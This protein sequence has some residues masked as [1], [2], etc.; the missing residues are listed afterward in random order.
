MAR[1]DSSTHPAA[2][3][4]RDGKR[5]DYL[6]PRNSAGLQN[7]PSRYGARKRDCS[8]EVGHKIEAPV[9]KARQVQ[10]SYV[11][12]ALPTGIENA[13]AVAPRPRIVLAPSRWRSI[14]RHS[15]S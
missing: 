11:E 5:D 1:N 6:R 7:C 12:A 10:V 8:I 2:I 14:S 15:R 13:P 4:A 3:F 9:G